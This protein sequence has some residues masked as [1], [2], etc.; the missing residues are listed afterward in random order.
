METANSER[1]SSHI[2]HGVVARP[3]V[4]DHQSAKVQGFKAQT[5]CRCR[6]LCAEEKEAT[7]L[8]AAVWHLAKHVLAK[9][10]SPH[11]GGFDSM[12]KWFERG[13]VTSDIR[14][15]ACNIAFY[16]IIRWFLASPSDGFSKLGL[17]STELVGRLFIG[18]LL[19]REASLDPF[20]HGRTYTVD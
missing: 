17:R 9:A 19:S 10:G 13:V 6:S 1:P 3:I 20:P 8:A 12:A 4:V 16:I 11:E 7:P 14:D 18:G 2:P 5:P 15:V